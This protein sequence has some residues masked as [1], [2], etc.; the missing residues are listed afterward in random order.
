VSR[1]KQPLE[2]GTVGTSVI[3]VTQEVEARRW[4]VQGQPKQS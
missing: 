4:W 3:P 2:Q 1:S